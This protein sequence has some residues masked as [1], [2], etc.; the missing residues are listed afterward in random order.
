MTERRCGIEKEDIQV[1][2]QRAWFFPAITC[3]EKTKILSDPPGQ[4]RPHIL[5]P[6]RNNNT[7]IDSQNRE[8]K[9]EI[10]DGA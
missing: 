10:E 3:L 8:D 4:K 5:K 7:G 9:N 6:C 1:W 2:G